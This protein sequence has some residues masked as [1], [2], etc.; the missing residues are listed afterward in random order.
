MKNWKYILRLIGILAIGILLVKMTSQFKYSTFFF[1]LI[2]FGILVIIGVLF[3][4]WSIFSDLKQFRINKKIH[5]LIPIAFGIIFTTGISIRNM[6]I[7]SNFDKPTLFRVFYDGDYNGT[8]IDFKTD[9]TYIFD[10]SSIGMS[11]Y[12]Y[13]TYKMKGNKI[14]LDKNE[15]DNVI[16]TNLLE[17]RPKTI[18]YSDRTETENY[19]YQVNKIGEILKNKTKFRVVVD[20]RK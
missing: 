4:I 18:E 17:I 13:G 8:G 19:V 7:N 16:K 1:D 20:N 2:I 10:N 11:D 6:Q 14:T 12:Q 15:L 9:G 5:R 3:L